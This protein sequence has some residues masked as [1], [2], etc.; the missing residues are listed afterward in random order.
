MVTDHGG[1]FPHGLMPVVLVVQGV[2]FAYAAVGRKTLLLIPLIAV[3]LV[4]GWFAI[5][6]R[7]SRAADEELPR[8]T[9]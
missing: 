1:V 6:R 5:R 8:F 3:I 9:K 2:I 4:G 7:V